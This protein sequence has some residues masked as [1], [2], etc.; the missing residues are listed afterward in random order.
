MRRVLLGAIVLILLGVGYLVLTGGDAPRPSLAQA[1]RPSGEAAE[2]SVGPVRSVITAATKNTTIEYS[3]GN[4]ATKPRTYS[5]SVRELSLD[6][7]PL[8]DGPQSAARWV[9]LPDEITV[10]PG[11]RGKVPVRVTLPADRGASQRRIAVVVTDETVDTSG[12]VNFKTA[13]STSVY[14]EGTGP[15]VRKASMSDL[16]LPLLSGRGITASARLSNEGPVFL[17]PGA[18]KG[19][20]LGTT[21]STNQF[22]V[23]GPAVR[24]GETVT[25]AGSVRAPTA[26]WCE[27]RLSAPDGTGATEVVGHVLVLPWWWLLG[28]LLVLMAVSLAVV[29]SRRGLTIPAPEGP[30]IVVP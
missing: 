15:V 12:N 9:D 20:I 24:P 7:P 21:S 5:M 26:C 17:V 6:G 29:R 13:I 8:K 25:V 16:D 28:A 3:V 23:S 1:A 10:Q 22:P 19:T 30:D 27:V 11:S 18:Q 14:V 2:L 4:N